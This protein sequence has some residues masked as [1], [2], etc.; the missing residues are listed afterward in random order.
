MEPVCSLGS[1]V[2]ELKNSIR[3][4]HI[5]LGLSAIYPVFYITCR[6]GAALCPHDLQIAV[7]LS[8]IMQISRIYFYPKSAIS[9]L[10]SKN[11][12]SDDQKQVLELMYFSVSL[13]RNGSLLVC[14]TTKKHSF[15][16]ASF[17]LRVLLSSQF[18]T[19]F[20]II[21]RGHCL[22]PGRA[23]HN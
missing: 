8:Y 6:A 9:P 15:S 21:L 1:L 10:Y 23:I 2:Q 16:L 3:H 7:I 12:L 14:L 19:N 13:M 17:T 18:L 11:K 5:Y 4:I 20:E 22:C